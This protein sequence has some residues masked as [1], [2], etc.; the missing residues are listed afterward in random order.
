MRPAKSRVHGLEQ[1][2]A[3]GGQYSRNLLSLRSI[4]WPNAEREHGQPLL[5]ERKYLAANEGVRSR[6][7]FAREIGYPA[8]L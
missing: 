7:V 6:R 1:T 3:L 5:A 8:H 4:S 2:G